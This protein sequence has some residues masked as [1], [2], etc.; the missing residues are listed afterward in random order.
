MEAKTE[1][2][3]EITPSRR[4]ETK[5][6]TPDLELTKKFLASLA[7]TATEFVFQTFDDQEDR[8]DRSLARVISGP[9]EKVAG[10]LTALNR[11]GA[12][13][14]VTVN[15]TVNGSRKKTDIIGYRAIFREADEPNLPA[16][17]ITPQIVVE[18]SPGK[19]HEYLLLADCDDGDTW[20]SIMAT[21]VHEYGSDPNAKDRSRVL[22]LPGFYHQKNPDQPHLVR[23]V[24]ESGETRY[25]LAEIAKLIPPAQKPEKRIPACSVVI[26]NQYGRR[27]LANELA[28]LS[29]T[30]EG[31]RN[32]QLNKSAYSLGQLVAGGE[33]EQSQVQTALLSAAVGIGLMESEA[34]QTIGSGIESGVKKPRS[35]PADGSPRTIKQIDEP[36][37]AGDGQLVLDPADP[38]SNA[39]AFIKKLYCCESIRT[40]Q[41]WQGI[42]YSWTGAAYS[43]MPAD[44]IRAALYDFLTNSLIDGQKGT[45]PFRPNRHRVADLHDSLKAAANLSREYTPPCWLQDTGKPDAAELIALSNGLLHLPTRT[46]HKADPT[47]FTTSSLPFNYESNVTEPT[48]WHH[49]LKTIWPDDHEAISTLQEIFG[50]LLTSDTTQQKIFLIVGPLRSGKGTI[51]RVL[52]ALLGQHNVAGPTLASLSQSFGLAPLIGKKLAVI[53]DARLGSRADQHAITERLLSISGEDSLSIPRKFMMD[54]TAKL[55]VRFM[56]LSNELPRLA[57]TSGALASRFIV[58]TMTKSFFGK[59]DPGLTK[60]LLTELPGILNWA[61]DGWQRLNERGHFIQP[62]S[63]NEA[64]RELADLS[65]PISAFIRDNCILDPAA[66]VECSRL[67]LGWKDWCEEQGRDYPGTVQTFGRDL[68]AA[69]PSLKTSQPKR[70]DERVR[71][72]VGIT[73]KTLWNAMER[74]HNH[75]TRKS[76]NNELIY[77]KNRNAMERVP[78]RAEIPEREVEL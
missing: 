53:A 65:S 36:G 44:D 58:I 70:G 27:A 66:E 11:R 76:E 21:M 46:L 9:P 68:R 64:I 72:Y 19:H 30:P 26:S 13:V 15:K 5:T 35:A 52:T 49:F 56:I 69:V 29:G 34:R 24:Q 32:N 1:I 47:F 55:D 22:R 17:P 61:I 4:K 60:R 6:I 12:G 54:Y 31:S 10:Q 77:T 39:Q 74:A 57:D 59:E 42:F 28:D 7:P 33:L 78:L 73:L 23:I 20:D 71:T 41:F 50:L 16:L 3:Q 2:M 45:K 8:K 38:F 48:A 40:L 18:T 75:C 62:K 43:Q 51:A 67:Y 14:F 25:S 37:S 63:S